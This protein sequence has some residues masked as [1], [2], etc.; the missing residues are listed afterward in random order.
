MRGGENMKKSDAELHVGA[1]E[2]SALLEN[3]CLVRN[4]FIEQLN[5]VLELIDSQGRVGRA[6]PSNQYFQFLIAEQERIA[7]ILKG[8]DEKVLSWKVKQND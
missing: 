4:G 2:Y 3:Y 7:K 8:L 5:Q 1:E 6:E